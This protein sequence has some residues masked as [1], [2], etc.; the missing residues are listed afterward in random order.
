MMA[1]KSK[2]PTRTQVIQAWM[3]NHNAIAC[4]AIAVVIAAT[5]TGLF[6]FVT[7]SGFGASADFVYNQ[8]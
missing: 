5:L 2:K 6:L 8:F 1:L 7:L 4:A 3:N